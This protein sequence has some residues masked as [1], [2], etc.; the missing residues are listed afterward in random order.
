MR[1]LV[2][3]AL[4]LRTLNA[5][6]LSDSAVSGAES[7]SASLAPLL[8]PADIPTESQLSE[9]AAA[10]A[11][12]ITSSSDVTLP[13]S[14]PEVI[15]PEIPVVD[16]AVPT[17]VIDPIPI[18]TETASGLDALL[19]S[20]ISLN[21]TSYA[22]LALAAALVTPPASGALAAAAASPSASTTVGAN[23]AVAAAAGRPRPNNA[24]SIRPG[25]GWAGGDDGVYDGQDYG[26]DWDDGQGEYEDS[27]GEVECPSDCVCEVEKPEYDGP[28]G[29]PPPGYSPPPLP[30]PDYEEDGG[31]G[32]GEDGG[33][34]DGEDAPYGR[35]K[36]RTRQAASGG[37]ARFNWPGA[38]DDSGDGAADGDDLPAWLY[39]SS[40]VPVPHARCPKAC[41]NIGEY[42]SKPTG[43]YPI[44][45]APTHP[46]GYKPAPTG[47]VAPYK[48]SQSA[49][50]YKSGNTTSKDAYATPSWTTLYSSGASG[51]P[52]DYTGDT[53]AGI[54]PKTC[55][56]DSD[57]DYCDITT[58]C[59]TTGGSKNYCACRAGYMASA[60]NAKDFSKQFRVEG[61]PFVYVAPGVVCDKV[62]GDYSCKDVLTR[63][64]CA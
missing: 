62:C 52:A 37:F 14:T 25:G 44:D 21:S 31:Y 30:T 64:K 16:L 7:V 13:L 5:Q 48:P 58:S 26:D 38:A 56:P 57:K 47:Y 40:G 28:E 8:T 15:L 49:D 60:W 9:A 50:P 11:A 23:R 54:C 6:N 12:P 42:E 33:Y 53:L 4:L 32:E 2:F 39:E 29:P 63:P 1:S 20:S 27:Y 43:K 61:H 3:G 10:A 24:G 36:L 59:T 45:P 41:C 51:K 22:S 34:E 19:V 18:G 35:R 17:D 55:N 46:S